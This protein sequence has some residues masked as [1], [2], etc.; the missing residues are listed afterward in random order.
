MQDR[1]S[2]RA[3]SAT[4]AV[5][6]TLHCYITFAFTVHNLILVRIGIDGAVRDAR[7]NRASDVVMHNI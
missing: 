1:S 2:T 7:R 4:S 5:P 3:K 6:I